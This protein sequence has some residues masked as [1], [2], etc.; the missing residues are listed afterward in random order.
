MPAGVFSFASGRSVAMP[1]AKRRTN[2]AQLQRDLAN[3]FSGAE[4]DAIDV[5]NQPAAQLLGLFASAS[6]GSGKAAAQHFPDQSGGQ[7]DSAR[8]AQ[9]MTIASDPPALVSDVTFQMALAAPQPPARFSGQ[10]SEKSHAGDDLPEYLRT[11]E[12][13]GHPTVVFQTAGRMFGMPVSLEQLSKKHSR[14]S[15]QS[16]RQEALGNEDQL[17]G[18]TADLGVAMSSWDD[19]QVTFLW[20]F[21]TRPRFNCIAQDYP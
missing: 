19:S 21:I 12:P 10:H 17:S 13:A 18:A 1:S 16:S 2:A 5:A 7:G 20:T 9:G 4:D 3:L 14:D 11:T 15:V 8:A 6:T